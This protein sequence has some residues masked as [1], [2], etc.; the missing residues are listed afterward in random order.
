MGQRR[1]SQRQ[2]TLSCWRCSRSCS[3]SR[4]RLAADETPAVDPKPTG[5][6]VV[7]EARTNSI[8]AVPLTAAKLRRAG[9]SSRMRGKA[10]ETRLIDRQRRGSLA[11]SGRREKDAGWA[12]VASQK[13][14]RRHERRTTAPK[15]SRELHAMHKHEH[16]HK[17][18]H[19]HK[20]HVQSCSCRGGRSQGVCVAPESSGRRPWQPRSSTRAEEVV[21]EAV[22]SSR[23][24]STATMY[25]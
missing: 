21:S 25:S 10:R 5:V 18:K 15:G 9:G 2:N 14:H 19:K 12:T 7:E 13:S 8:A 17:H 24:Y 11:V 23:A 22:Q 20:R 1:N 6:V 16:E 4:S 3:G